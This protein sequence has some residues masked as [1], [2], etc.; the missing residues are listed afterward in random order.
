VSHRAR[1]LGTDI[2]CVTS[3][4]LCL[5][6]A[7][8]TVTA[9]PDGLTSVQALAR[10]QRRAQAGDRSAWMISAPSQDGLKDGKVQDIWTNICAGFGKGP[11]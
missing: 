11:L 1:R 7:P 8:R 3:H 2:E 9:A 6:W 4:F 10:G 5:D